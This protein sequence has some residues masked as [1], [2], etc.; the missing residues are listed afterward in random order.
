MLTT[1]RQQSD[2]RARNRLAQQQSRKRRLA[3]DEAQRQRVQL[4][5]DVVEEMCSLLVGVVDKLLETEAIVREHPPVA[6]VLKVS[7]ARI[8]KLANKAAEA[9]F[10][11]T[12]GGTGAE[13][14]PSDDHRMDDVLPV[15][16]TRLLAPQSSLGTSSGGA[17]P[18]RDLGSGYVYQPLTAT[19]NDDALHGPPDSMN[20]QLTLS[21]PDSNFSLLSQPFGNGWFSLSASM[22]KPGDA[23][24]QFPPTLID[25]FT[26]RLLR[27]SLVRG[28]FVLA[29]APDIPPGETE[30]VFGGSL[31]SR[32][33]EDLLF[34]IR[35]VL[36]P[37]KDHI[38]RASG[39]MW[40]NIP[41]LL[42]KAGLGE[43][44]TDFVTTVDIQDR[45]LELGATMLDLDTM[46]VTDPSSYSR[47]RS[48]PATAALFPGDH[49]AKS[50]TSSDSESSAHSWSYVDFFATR[51]PDKREPP[52]T[53]LRI[54]V[55]ML[56]SAL[57]PIGVCVSRG[58]VFPREKMW[59]ALESA[60]TAIF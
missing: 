20:A 12:R 36:G 33:R 49:D 27:T 45:L 29:G 16:D 18:E 34:S 30:R 24:P 56:I 55:P 44:G 57:V 17:S 35:W 1:C 41:L 46:E 58:P 22:L 14:K 59:S 32:T 6:G 60:I 39:A 52:P 26:I 5:E 23:P 11:H 40:E 51:R 48:M 7:M 43:D 37:G 9:G 21:S 42:Q 3:A 47:V 50:T 13:Q 53:K 25:A 4:L 54:S 15:P 19:I 2:R 8:L 31:R 28:Y 10:H 38:Y